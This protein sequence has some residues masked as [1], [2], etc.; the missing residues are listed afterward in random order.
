MTARSAS[1]DA[2]I[3]R[4]MRRTSGCSTMR[5]CSPAGAPGA[6]PCLRSFA[7]SSAIWYA[8]SDTDRPSRP[9]DSRALFIIVNM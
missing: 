5:L 3:V 4:S 9:T 8:R 1:M 2:R 7:Y 6:R